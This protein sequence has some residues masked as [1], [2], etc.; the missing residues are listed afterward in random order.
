[1][2]LG[3]QARRPS[4]FP[5][6]MDDTGCGKFASSKLLGELNV[7]S[8]KSLMC[9][10]KEGVI[11]NFVS[12]DPIALPTEAIDCHHQERLHFF[13]EVWKEC[14]HCNKGE[15]FLLSDDEKWSIL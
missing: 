1:M 6:D 14:D 8:C 2:I 13:P 4:S 10:E 7:G 3:G 5:G 12:W 15:K 9:I 11:G